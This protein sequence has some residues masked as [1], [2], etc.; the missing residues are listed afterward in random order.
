MM[1]RRAPGWARLVAGTRA[2][3]LALVLV[4]LLVGGVGHTT[5]AFSARSLNPGNTFATG[6]LGPPGGLAATLQADGGTVR[7]TWTATSTAWASGHRVYRAPAAAGPYTPIAQ[8]APPAT[9]SYD[10]VPGPGVFYYQVRAYYA[11][12]GAN[13]ESQQHPQAGPAKPLA[14]FAFA[15]IPSPQSRRAAFPVTV[16]ALASDNTT[17]T[18][19]TGTVSFTVASGNITPATSAAFANGTATTSVTINQTA[20]ITGE[21]IT[22]RGGTPARTGTSNAFD[23]K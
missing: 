7:L 8:L 12:N 18:A 21:T 19:F 6:S 3:V 16:T 5:A 11:A 23:V 20:P 15:P 22:A 2:P 17:V 4:L 9:R 1:R 10:D 14:R 13:W